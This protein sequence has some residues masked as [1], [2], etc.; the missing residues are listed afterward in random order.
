MTTNDGEFTEPVPEAIMGTVAEAPTTS[1]AAEAAASAMEPRAAAPAPLVAPRSSDIVIVG[2]LALVS[3][4]GDI[5][6]GI[7]YLTGAS[8]D[9]ARTLPG[10]GAVIL[11]VLVAVIA[12]ALLRGSNAA[13]WALAIVM[14]ARIGLHVWA[15]IAIGS[16]AAAVAMIEILIAAVVLIMLFSRESTAFLTGNRE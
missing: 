12:F 7:A 8:D 4:I 6:A 11:G 2:V 10:W 9:S 5:V 15:W 16:D 13:R 14:I 3:A 1:P